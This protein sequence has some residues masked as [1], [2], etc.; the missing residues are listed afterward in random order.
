MKP[1]TKA[2]CDQKFVEAPT[3]LLWE[4]LTENRETMPTEVY[5]EISNFLELGCLDDARLALS[6]WYFETFGQ[7]AT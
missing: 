6:N 4:I 3:E 7:F 5:Q 2:D 1:L